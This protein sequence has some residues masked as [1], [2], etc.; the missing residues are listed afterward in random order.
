GELEN[1]TVEK[2]Q[3][4]MKSDDSKNKH[5]LNLFLIYQRH[6]GEASAKGLEPNSE[7]QVETMTA[8]ENE[9]KD[10]Y[11]LIPA[12]IYIYKSEAL[13]SDQKFEEAKA[14]V[15]EG[16]A[17]YP[18]SIPLKVYRYMDTKDVN[19]KADLI[20]NHSNHWLVQH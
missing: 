11:G 13:N 3:T 19:L 14:E 6:I 5:L 17:V 4:F 2:L 8:L 9:F 7:F 18:N 15:K 10:L 1:G 12:I 16:L 20:S